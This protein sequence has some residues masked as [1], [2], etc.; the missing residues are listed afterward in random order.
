M[1]KA[2][3]RVQGRGG[4][5]KTMGNGQSC[6]ARSRCGDVVRAVGASPRPWGRGEGR[7]G[8][9]KTGGVTKSV[10]HGQG[11]GAWPRW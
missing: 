3:G 9:A 2:A 11:V 7:G 5:S 8:V 1:A 6:G 4:V 10:K